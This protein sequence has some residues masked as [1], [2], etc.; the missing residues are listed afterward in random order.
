M[1]LKFFNDRCKIYGIT[2]NNEKFEIL[3]RIWPRSDIIDFIETH[4]EDRTYKSLIEFLQS[5]SSKL[6]RILGASPS[7]SEPVKFQDLF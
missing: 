3:Q 2:D 7:W 6:P 5:K 1:E 4:D